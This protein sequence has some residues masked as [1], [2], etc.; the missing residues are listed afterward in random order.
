MAD[1]Y[2]GEIRAFP[3]Q[4]IPRGWLECAGQTLQVVQYQAL[5][6]LLGNIW[7]GTAG[8]T[9]VL[10]NLQGLAVNAPGQA[11]SGG[12]IIY[13]YGQTYGADTVVLTSESQVPSHN[14][15]VTEHLVPAVHL[16]QVTQS[17]PIANQSWLTRPENVVNDTLAHAI[18]AF[19]RA[20]ATTDTTLAST[21]VAYSGTAP[22]AAHDNHQPYL[23]LVYCIC[24]E[25]GYY[26]IRP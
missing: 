12:A 6:S 20:G 3:Y 24:A 23:T 2:Y 1:A 19:E 8:Q 13:Q 22:A 14:H 21:T 10:P 18:P 9:F 5:Y 11:P 4:Y 26:P 17:T 16:T 7:G 15:T 25:D